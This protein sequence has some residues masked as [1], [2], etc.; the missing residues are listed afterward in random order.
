[1]DNLLKY[2]LKCKLDNILLRPTLWKIF[3]NYLSDEINFTIWLEKTKSKRD[4]FKKISGK[5]FSARKISGDPL[6]GGTT[7]VNLNFIIKQE[8]E[9]FLRRQRTKENNL[10]RY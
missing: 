5:Y 9:P 3:L 2:C 7:E 10:T 8:L 1:M 4:A 6:G